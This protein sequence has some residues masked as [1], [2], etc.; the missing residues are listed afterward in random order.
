[1]TFRVAITRDVLDAEGNFVFKE[2]GLELLDAERHISYEFMQEL[3]PTATPDQLQ[4]YDGALWLIPKV[5]RES[6]AGVEQLA[7]IARVGVGYDMVDLE[8]CTEADVAVFI[9]RGAVN[10]SVAE[11]IV[12]WMLML[13]H[14]AALKDRLVREQRW[15]EKG[16]H[17]GTELRERVVGSVG[18]GG[19]GGALRQ[20]LEGFGIARFLVFDPFMAPEQ[21]TAA[22]GA[23]VDLDTLMA[24]SDYVTI[25]CPL[26]PQTRGLIG[27]AQLGL[28]KPTAYLINTAR[29]GIVDEPAL[30]E[31]LR[32]GRIAGAA[33][34]VFEHEPPPADH[35]FLTLENIILAPHAIAWTDE[36]FRDIG[37]VACSGLVRLSRGELPDHIVNPAVVERPG[38]QGKLARLRERFGC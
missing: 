3:R 36:I 2:M 26:T 6:L 1:M 23:P 33:I 28:M 30:A 14:K 4:G 38:F 7:G 19:I 35:P 22:G 15:A 13:G 29:G 24:E 9:S 37:R 31:A 10:R 20:L 5:T 8:A 21:V 25:N 17:N 34:D 32:E 11:A 12:T 16:R 18:F 27:A